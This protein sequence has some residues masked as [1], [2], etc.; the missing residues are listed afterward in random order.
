MSNYG[1][2]MLSYDFG[3]VA[4]KKNNLVNILRCGDIRKRVSPTFKSTIPFGDGSKIPT[5]EVLSH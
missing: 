2:M 3:P 4:Y 1:E 5:F